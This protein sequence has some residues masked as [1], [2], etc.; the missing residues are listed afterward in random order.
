MT[1]H[2]RNYR[3]L[4]VCFI[5]VLFG[6]VPLRFVEVKKSRLVS[7]R[8]QVLGDEVMFKEKEATEAEIVASEVKLDEK[9]VLPDSDIDHL[10]GE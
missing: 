3:T 10:I 8:T 4:V 9:I 5:I 7:P 2:K 1:D 6:L